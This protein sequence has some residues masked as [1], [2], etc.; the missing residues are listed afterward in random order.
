[1]PV[2]DITQA[3]IAE[4]N[5]KA[6]EPYSTTRKIKGYLRNKVQGGIRSTFGGSTDAKSMAKVVGRNAVSLAPK[7]LGSAAKKIPVIGSYASTLVEKGSQLVA[8]KVVEK[9]DQARASEL[10]AKGV[11]GTLTVREMT[12]M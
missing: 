7:A 1:M 10:R 5:E 3:I 2:S 8:D 11:A 12:E 4:A 9:I 6:N